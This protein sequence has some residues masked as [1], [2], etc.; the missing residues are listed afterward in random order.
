MTGKFYGMTEDEFSEKV[1][2][3]F[4]KMVHEN[5]E[6]RNLLRELLREAEEECETRKRS[7][8]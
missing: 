5:A 8:C 6:V 7:S 4:L 2:E 3:R 1:A